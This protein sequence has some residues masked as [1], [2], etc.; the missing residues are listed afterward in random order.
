MLELFSGVDFPQAVAEGLCTRLLQQTKRDTQA[1]DSRMCKRR[2]S[3]IA[4]ETGVFN[5][6]DGQKNRVERSEKLWNKRER[7]IKQ[8]KTL[9]L[10]WGSCF[11]VGLLSSM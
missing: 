8:K 6:N 2:T 5:L 1:V 7:K 3:V 10:C 11:W 4:S 9:S